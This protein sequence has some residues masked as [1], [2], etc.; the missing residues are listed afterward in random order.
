[1]T[2]FL[3]YKSKGLQIVDHAFVREY[4]SPRRGS[5]WNTVPGNVIRGATYD[6][7]E[8]KGAPGRTGRSTK[9]SGFGHGKD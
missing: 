3:K 5:Y 4:C 9:P 7:L 2:T 6:Q 8:N 1:V